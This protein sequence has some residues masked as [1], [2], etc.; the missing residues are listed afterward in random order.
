MIR[1]ADVVTVRSTMTPGLLSMRALDGSSARRAL[2][3]AGFDEPGVR[4]VII[5]LA[6]WQ[7]IAPVDVEQKINWRGLALWLVSALVMTA[8]TIAIAARVMR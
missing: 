8:A 4:L 1:R 3:A 6:D 7:E 2:L 5:S